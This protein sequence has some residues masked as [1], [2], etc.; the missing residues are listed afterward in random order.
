MVLVFVTLKRT[1]L[2]PKL[3]GE[4][5]RERSKNDVCATQDG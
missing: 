4:L 1:E 2:T 3:E 5:Q